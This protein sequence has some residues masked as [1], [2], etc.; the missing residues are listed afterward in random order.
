MG[1]PESPA[2]GVVPLT[3]KTG[4]HEHDFGHHDPSV[5][6]RTRWVVALTLAMMI[7][8]IVAGLA[9]GSMALLADGWHMGTHAAA[10][11]VAAIAYWYARRHARDPRFS[12]GTGKVGALGGFA[13]AVGLALVALLV[14]GESAT[15]LASPALIRFDEAI[16]VCFLGLG[17][18]VASA[19]ILKERDHEREDHGHHHHDRDH[20]R[21][22]AYLHVLADALT[23]VLALIAL[24]AG[25][26]LGWTWMDPL[27]GIAGS[28]V[29]GWWS[30]GLLRDTTAVLLD[31]EIDSHVRGE[32]QAA[33]ENDGHSKVA[34]LHVW[35]VGPRRL[36]AMVSVTTTLP[37]Q[38][39]DYRRTLSSFGELAHVSVEVRASMTP[40]EAL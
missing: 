30:Y 32:I 17:V 27:M 6:A 33:L 23:S 4:R 1:R 38:P 39:D 8:E 21:R 12:F 35:R 5:E 20:N 2:L 3:P 9:F 14:L 13:S 18:N 31:A 25:K 19:F 29:I 15:R 16:A 26:W 11:G 40:V 24:Y 10:L 22:A 37:K 28:L 7:G 34:D 36:A